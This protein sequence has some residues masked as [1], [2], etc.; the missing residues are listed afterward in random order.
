LFIYFLFKKLAASTQIKLIHL[1]SLK[2]IFIERFVTITSENFNRAFS[3]LKSI[4]KNSEVGGTF[5]KE[6]IDIQ[7]VKSLMQYIR[8]MSLSYNDL[9][10]EFGDEL[11]QD[12]G[13]LRDLGGIFTKNLNDLF[14]KKIYAKLDQI[15]S[16][17]TIGEGEN[18]NI[19]KFYFFYFVLSK[20]NDFVIQIRNSSVRFLLTED[21]QTSCE[22]NMDKYINHVFIIFLNKLKDI[23]LLF[24]NK[25]AGSL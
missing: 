16:S 13:M 25:D 12:D 6:I 5:S 22:H 18:L 11:T 2:N 1:D 14:F 10:D 15:I 9:Y 3:L 19:L 24:M 20:M 7:I 23:K 8:D 21:L 17:L 4:E